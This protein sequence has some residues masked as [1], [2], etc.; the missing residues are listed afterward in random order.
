MFGSRVSWVSWFRVCAECNP[1]TSEKEVCSD[2]T[3]D[4]SKGNGIPI[5]RNSSRT[6]VAEGEEG[7]SMSLEG[8][9]PTVVCSKPMVS[10][11]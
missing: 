2:R 3:A 6:G 10:V 4:E 5:G 9:R 1:Y 7:I 8:V 11:G